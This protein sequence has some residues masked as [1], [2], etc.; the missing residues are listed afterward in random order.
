MSICF[1][2]FFWLHSSEPFIA[3]FWWLPCFSPAFIPNLSCNQV[4][5]FIFTT[6]GHKQ[7]W[8]NIFTASFTSESS[9]VA[10]WWVLWNWIKFV[11]E[12]FDGS[13]SNGCSRVSSPIS[14]FWFRPPHLPT[15]LMPWS[16]P[17]FDSRAKWFT[18]Q[19]KRPTCRLKSVQTLITP[20]RLYQLIRQLWCLVPWTTKNS[21]ISRVC[22]PWLLF[23]FWSNLLVSAPS[24]A[25][26]FWLSN[27]FVS[28][29]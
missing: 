12:S 15:R 21:V 1:W 17:I 23:C 18:H 26:Y 22:F 25:P 6:D 13:R 3:D 14:I 11:I 8:G 7:T 4:V 10:R 9:V 27:L 19:Y 20:T 2:F 28:T 5:L 16:S 29:V 24:V